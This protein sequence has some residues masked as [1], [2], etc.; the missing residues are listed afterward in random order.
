MIRPRIPGFNARSE[1]VN[2]ITKTE[3]LARLWAL[4]FNA[5]NGRVKECHKDS[6]A[7]KKNA[8]MH[9]IGAI[10][11]RIRQCI[12]GPTPMHLRGEPGTYTTT[13][14]APLDYYSTVSPCF[15]V[16]KV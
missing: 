5:R 11:A 10:N 16:C 2:G 14:V 12:G 15:Q 3:M 9:L 8:P 13:F 1:R 6:Y 7:R 4:G